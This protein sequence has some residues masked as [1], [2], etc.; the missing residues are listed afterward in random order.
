MYQTEIDGEGIILN[1][2]G[3][4]QSSL[5]GYGI[6]INESSS[7]AIRTVLQ[8]YFIKEIFMAQYGE[9]TAGYF[10]VTDSSGNLVSGLEIGDITAIEL[11]FNDLLPIYDIA[12]FSIKEASGGLYSFPLSASEM[13][14]LSV[15]PIITMVSPL[16]IATPLPINTIKVNEVK[17]EVD[18]KANE[19]IS[20]VGQ[21]SVDVVTEIEILTDG[22]TTNVNNKIETVTDQTNKLQFDGD[23]FVKS[24]AQNLGTIDISSAVTAINNNTNSKTAE[25][26]VQTDKIPDVLTK[27]DNAVIDLKEKTATLNFSIEYDFITYATKSIIKF[28]D[29]SRPLSGNP[30][31]WCYVYDS[32]GNKPTQIGSIATR[33]KVY[34]WSLVQPA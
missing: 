15:C 21:S 7:S 12:T 17:D 33:D 25:I 24:V 4:F 3:N 23:N 19:I 18:I 2:S 22:I 9:Q 13:Q 31:Y 16:H 20:A 10:I 32:L 34:K 6:I 11:R 28:Y 27:L 29:S 8:N 1:E 14:H 30:D 26:K 5:D